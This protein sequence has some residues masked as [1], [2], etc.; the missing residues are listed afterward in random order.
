VRD[1]TPPREP[2]PNAK[3]RV[4]NFWSLL[5]REPLPARSYPAFCV[6]SKR[7][8]PYFDTCIYLFFGG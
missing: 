7:V 2:K 4:V 3:P 8:A 5:E 6:R 1:R